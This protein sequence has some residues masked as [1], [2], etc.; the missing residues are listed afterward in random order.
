MDVASAVGG[1]P[2]SGA[3]GGAAGG[4]KGQFVGQCDAIR[5]MIQMTAQMEP[6]YAPYA[7]KMLALNDAGM[8]AAQNGP[9]GGQPN[10]GDNAAA[11][12]AGAPG[13]PSPPPVGSPFPG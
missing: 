10:P 11:Q 9:P 2:S 4:P 3:P 13:P 7:D 5:R 6:A 12:T 1:A 8:A